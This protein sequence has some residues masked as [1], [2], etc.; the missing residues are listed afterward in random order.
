MN[1]IFD[2]GIIN[3][4]IYLNGDWVN[5]NLYIKDERIQVISTQ[6]LDCNEE[7]DACGNL[8]LPG[9]IDPHVHFNLNVGKYTSV[10]DFKSGSISA[11]YGGITTIID[12][13]DP[14]SRTEKLSEA[15][16]NRNEVAKESVVDYS[17]HSTIAEIEGDISSFIRESKKLGIPSI[18]LFTTYSSSNR[19]T[20]DRTICELLKR[21]KAEK[22][23]VLAHCENDSII[24]E[25]NVVVKNHS[26]ARPAVS[27]IS[28]IMKLAQIA[29]YYNGQIY[30]V[31]TT[32]GST[33]E[34]LNK[35]YNHML[36]K[37]IFVES[38]PHYFIFDDNKYSESDG[39]KYTM[40]PPLREQKEVEKLKK[41]I[42]CIDTIGT[43]HCPFNTKEK[44]KDITEEIPMG[45]GGVEHSF[46]L[47]YSIFGDE[48]IDKFT[49][50]TARIHGLYPLKGTLQV[51]AY[52]DVVIFDP[53]KEHIISE[54]HSRCDYNL[55][56]N[57]NVKGK[58]IST[59]CR[60]KFIIKDCKFIGGCGK[61]LGRVL[62]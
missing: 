4:K 32:C 13:L 42:K 62:K 11:A 16:R 7:Y 53:K 36:N 54:Y 61:Y 2:L 22:V 33:I 21:S 44:N 35:K 51:G 43:D 17:F 59:I 31:H 18:K 10:D 56:S 47:M 39:Y 8:V 45:I 48:I 40:T 24:K 25:K 12:F 19:R 27:E 1:S 37:D 57:M 23:L 38:C 3:G 52:G 49:E 6:Y 26:L 60:G 15:F 20:Y 50:N 41:M 29:E 9:L 30:F 14:V 5:G 46:S 28:E 58:I 34:A 55:Y